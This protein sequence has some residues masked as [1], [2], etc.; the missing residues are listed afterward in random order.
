M[1]PMNLYA[2]ELSGRAQITKPEVGRELLNDKVDFHTIFAS[3]CDVIHRDRHEDLNT[4]S[5]IDVELICHACFLVHFGL[6]CYEIVA[7]LY[8]YGT[9]WIAGTHSGNPLVFYLA[10]FASSDGG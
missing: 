5:V 9:D 1:I 6:T 2:Q 8:G 3:Q 10:A 7:S 4:I